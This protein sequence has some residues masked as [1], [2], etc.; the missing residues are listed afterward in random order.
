VVKS[1]NCVFVNARSLMNNF[2]VEELQIYA[3]EHKLDILGVAETWLN[4]DISDSEAAIAGFTLY[5]KDRI[6]VKSGRGGGV[7]LYIRSNICSCA[8]DDLNRY[9]AESIFCKIITGKAKELY[10]GVCYKSPSALDEE[11]GQLYLAVKHVSQYHVLLMGDFNFP[12]IDW[13]H[14]DSDA[15]GSDFLT[16]VQDCFL[17]QHVH[18]ATRGN[19]VLDLVF[20]SEEN[21]VEDLIIK[22]HLSNSDHNI[23]MWK[24][25]Y[26]L[27][28]NNNCSNTNRNFNKASYPEMKAFLNNIDWYYEFLNLDAEKMWNKFCEI[29]N[30]VLCQFVPFCVKRKYNTPRWMTRRARKFRKYKSNMWKKYQ[31]SKAYNDWVEYKIA[32]NKTTCEYKKAKKNFEKKLSMNIKTD[33]KSFYAYTRSKSTVKQTV[34]PLKDSG[35]N[36]IVDNADMCSLLNGYFSSVFTLE[37]TSAVLP[38]VKQMYKGDQT[39]MLL[40]IVITPQVVEKFLRKLKPNKAPGVDGFSSQLFK[41]LAL[42]IS[43]P[44]SLIFNE[45]LVSGLIPAD[46]KKANVAV[47]HKA[48]SKKDPCN[49]RPISLTAQACK[50]MESILRDAITEYLHRLKLIQDSQHGFVKNRSCL[51]NLLTFLDF[52]HDYV[53]KGV[54]VD[55]VYLDFKKA[56]DKVPHCRLMLKVKA[57]G[58]GGV[59][60][61]WIENW[62]CNREQRVVLNGKFSEWIKV[63]SGVPQGSVL[64]PLLFVIYINDFENNLVNK[65]LK[66]A[67]DSKIFGEVSSE[68]FVEGLRLDLKQLCSWSED[69]LMVFN[70][71]KC[72]VVHFGKNNPR[73]I[74]SINGVNLCEVDEERD[75]GIIVQ[76]NL[77]VSSQCL[78]VVKTANKVLGMIKRSFASRSKEI[79][80]NLYKALVRPH[81]E[82]CIQAWRPYLKKDIDIIEGVQR[83]ATKIIDGFAHLSYEERLAE[84]R[85]TTLET[86]RLRGDLIE[87]FKMIRCDDY[88]DYKHF[89]QLSNTGL[90]GNC[91]K[92]YKNRFTTN[93]GKYSFSNRVV[94][95]WNKLSDE[96]VSSTTVTSFK[97]KLDLVIKNDWGFI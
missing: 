27:F 82:F 11:L 14:L 19:N 53:D 48:G 25:S 46:W 38:E 79:V 95:I 49:Y 30:E 91:F 81:L 90:R 54:P 70:T 32:L 74:Y 31:E 88:V 55:V 56:F 42:N 86:R 84:L 6:E 3:E 52:V 37:D 26:L 92:L 93:I 83:R 2:K 72:K 51:T 66:F 23:V 61:N 73:A 1:L 63:V 21:M 22:E 65:L 44:L 57:H 69:W 78:K 10:V 89:L 4:S 13:E 43:V 16:L 71:E 47:I 12:G 5:R 20:S 62:L 59:L 40:D 36:L 35:G 64:G 75:L 87:V 68:E 15:Q 8:C 34:G 85:L 67:D 94:D 97:A 80:L 18:T 58:I 33:P 29:I 7:L 45:S 39:N 96:V 50:V 9:K 24:L 28:D 60:S 17:F 77:K 76:E 41:E